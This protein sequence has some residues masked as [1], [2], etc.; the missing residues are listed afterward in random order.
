MMRGALSSLP[1]FVLGI[2]G[3]STRAIAQDVLLDIP[4]LNPGD[5]ASHG[6]GAGDWNG[7]G[8]TDLAIG[9]SLDSTYGTNAGAVHIFSGSDGGLITTLFGAAAGD[10]FGAALARIPDVDGDGLDDLAVDASGATYGGGGS[11]YVIGGVTGAPL[12]RIDCPIGESNFGTP[13]GSIGDVDGDGI[14]DLFISYGGFLEKVSIRS[15]ADGHEITSLSDSSG[16]NQLFGFAAS[17][18]DDLDLDGVR[19]LLVGAPF[20][21]DAQGRNLGA[22]YVMSTATN[23]V[24][25]THLGTFNTQ[26]LGGAV[27]T[28]TDYD[29]DGVHDYALGGRQNASSTSTNCFVESGASGTQIAK[30][31]P[32][33]KGLDLGPQ[34]AD[35][36]DLNGDGVSDLVF[37]GTWTDASSATHGAFFL[38]SGSS[39]RHL[40]R[41][42]IDDPFVGTLAPPLGDL[43]GNGFGDLIVGSHD[44]TCNGDVRVYEGDDLWLNATPT[45]PTAGA[46]LTLTTREGTP[47]ALTILVLVDVDGIPLF[48]VVGGIATFDSTGSRILSATIASGLA[49][50]DFTMQAFADDANGHVIASATQTVSCK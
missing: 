49:G 39:F 34:I 32:P 48:M 38:V 14:G 24:I 23:T 10:S 3:L 18:L 25:R 28:L 2:A 5:C 20:Y 37:D 8:V 7:D 44:F 30:I 47:G 45:Q 22:A 11:V 4:G 35:A 1:F 36:G 43:D 33:A 46:T 31:G 41:I 17:A 27:A 26:E 19:D 40:D 16:G 50:H 6:I 42:E 13:L 12:Y 21:V 9:A 29:G 15:G